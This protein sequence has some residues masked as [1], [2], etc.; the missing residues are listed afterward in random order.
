MTVRSIVDLDIRD[1]KF[2]SFATAF[3]KY[4]LQLAKTPNVWKSVGKEQ[5]AM[6]TQFERMTAALMAQNALALKSKEEDARRL[7]QLTTSEHLWH[8]IS[9]Y[10][11]TMYR[12]VIGIGQGVIKWGGLLAGA[13]TGFG[14]FGIDRLARGLAGTR[15]EAMGLNVQPAQLQAF[16]TDLGRFVNPEGFLGSVTAMETDKTKR[17]VWYSLLGLNRPMTGN[18]FNDSLTLL[19]AIRSFA[20]QYKGNLGM[21]GPQAAARGITDVASMAELMRMINTGNPEWQQQMSAARRDVGVFGQTNRS[22]FIWQQLSTQFQRAGTQMMD[23]FGKTLQGL[24]PALIRLSSG[25]THAITA[26]LGSPQFKH[27]IESLTSWLDKVTAKGFDAKVEG[28][29]K[30]VGAVAEAFHKLASAVVGPAVQQVKAQGLG[31]VVEQAGAG[32]L[33]F[34]LGGPIGA[35]V[36]ATSTKIAQQIGQHGPGTLRDWLGFIGPKGA[37]SGYKMFASGIENSGAQPPQTHPAPTHYANAAVPNITIQNQTGGAIF[38]S[39]N[40]MASGQ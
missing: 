14:L 23:A 26:V 7:R 33:G 36:A 5:A 17:R 35:A 24:A 3:D 29:I 21:L 8:N 20:L 27:G 15:Q 18:S 16:R 32:W 9:R 13:A 2:K 37:W 12:N 6:A 19:N 1:E 38:L 31:N 25:V 22:S 30:D 28:F 10:S 39:L 40:G 11:S 4:Q 34:L